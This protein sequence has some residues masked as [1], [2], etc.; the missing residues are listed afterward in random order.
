MN[1]PFFIFNFF[2][3]AIFVFFTTVILVE[4][5]LL[6]FRIKNYRVKYF[7]RIIPLFKLFLDITIYKFSSWG[8]LYGLNPVSC[9]KGSRTLAITLGK[10]P[11]F[12]Y[13][14]FSYI[15]ILFHFKNDKTF[16]IADIIGKSI[17]PTFV[18]ALSIF[19]SFL[20]FLSFIKIFLSYKKNLVLIR[21][22]AKDKKNFP[23][24]K[25]LS[26]SLKDQLTK[27][28]IV[29][30]TSE[31]ISSPCFIKHKNRI[32]LFPKKCLKIL[33]KKEL[34]AIIYHEL[35]HIFWKD[36]TFNFLILIASSL[37]LYIPFFKKW[38]KK[39]F[40]DREYACDQN[41]NTDSIDLALALK[42]CAK[43][44]LSPLRERFVISFIGEKPLEKRIKIL[45]SNKKNSKKFF[46]LLQ[47]GTLTIL[48]TVVLFGKFWIF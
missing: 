48:L 43:L 8:I 34:E 35:E 11:L 14:P 47:Y 42:K 29:L 17:D 19:F 22:L 5:L 23:K 32:I 16:S 6:I 46:R 30:A 3:N 33:N 7:A 27:N 24:K 38:I 28:K 12:N 20:A 41:I 40:K 2:I 10:T 9:E 13:N 25:I 4:F 45:L 39:I 26:P 37:F 31:K 36:R 21:K 15:S 44:K 1:I 18:I